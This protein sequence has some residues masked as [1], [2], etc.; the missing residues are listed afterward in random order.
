MLG[1][2]P[3]GKIALLAKE[4]RAGG[5][6]SS[7]NGNKAQGTLTA[8]VQLSEPKGRRAYEN[9]KKPSYSARLQCHDAPYENSI[10]YSGIL[11]DRS[12]E[13]LQ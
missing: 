13:H 8:N 3:T 11:L 12:Q 5:R 4:Q 6:E 1:A 9:L 2:K 7:R 10:F